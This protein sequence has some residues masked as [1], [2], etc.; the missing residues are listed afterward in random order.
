V[1]NPGDTLPPGPQLGAMVVD[2]MLD[3]VI[4]ADPQGVIRLWN[5]GA[6]VIFGYP[7]AEAVGQ[8]LD[9]VVPEKFRLS[10]GD[11][12]R[13]AVA[14]GHLRSHGKVLTTRAKH[15]YGCRLYVDFSFGILKDAAGTVVGL[16]AVGR[17]ATARHLGEVATRADVAQ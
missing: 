13:R 11:G 15:K 6:E 9:L 3:A 2:T 5:V 1:G 4:V 7:A 8:K 12:F 17:D 14:S 10:H 16:F